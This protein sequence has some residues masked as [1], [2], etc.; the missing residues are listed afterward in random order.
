M[1]AERLTTPPESFHAGDTLLWSTDL[2]DY[3]AGTWTLTYYLRG[4][5]KYSITA[6]ASGTTHHADATAATTAEHVPGEYDL[7][8]YVT[9]A[10]AR[11]KVSESRLTILEDLAASTSSHEARSSDEIALT[12]IKARMADMSARVE[13][14]YNVGFGGHSQNVNLMSWED[15]IRA[16]EYFQGKVSAQQKRDRVKQGKSSGSRIQIRFKSA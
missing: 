13:V 14:S 5:A 12:A 8:G 16:R 2:G 15:L 6:T 1:A 9:A 10:S 4:P 3:P 7:I 11:Y